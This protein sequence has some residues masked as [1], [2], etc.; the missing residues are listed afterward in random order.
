MGVIFIFLG[1]QMTKGGEGGEDASLKW[2]GNTVHM[3]T[4]DWK[5]QALRAIPEN[6]LP[7]TQL[8]PTATATP[9]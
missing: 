8:I 4:A 9:W 5:R 6:G 7:W 1:M 2:W 3:A